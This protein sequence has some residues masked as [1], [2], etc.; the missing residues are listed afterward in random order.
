MVIV[1]L[2]NSREN[3]QQKQ[4]KQQSCIAGMST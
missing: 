2:R 3:T 1:V 4:Q